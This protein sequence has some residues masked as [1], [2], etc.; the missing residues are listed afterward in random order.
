MSRPWRCA[1]LIKSLKIAWLD[2]P[3]LKPCAVT[4]CIPTA[5]SPTSDFVVTTLAYPI[6]IATRAAS[7]LQDHLP[8]SDTT[9]R[10]HGGAVTVSTHVPRG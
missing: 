6:A 4:G 1:D 8:W 10:V 7:Y 3:R 2:K 9:L 5:A